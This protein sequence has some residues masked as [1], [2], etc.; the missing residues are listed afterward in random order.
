MLQAIKL[1]AILLL[2]S[3]T[4]SCFKGGGIFKLPELIV[5]TNSTYLLRSRVTQLDCKL[6]DPNGEW[7]STSLDRTY[8]MKDGTPIK[9][10]VEDHPELVENDGILKVLKATHFAEG[11]YQCSSIVRNV[12]LAHDTTINSRLVS[13]PLKLRRAR[14]TK[15][16]RYATEKIRVKAG[17]VARLPCLG[18]PDV[19]PG[20]PEIWFEKQGHEGVQLGRT[21]N[22]RFISTPTGLQIALTQPVDAGKYYCMVRNPY[23]NLTR[24]APK[25]MELLV[26][27][28]IR[29]RRPDQPK[30][31]VIVYPKLNKSA[32]PIE[33]H[34]V[35]GQ[36]AIL[37]CVISDA[38]IRWNKPDF[39][40]SDVSIDDDRARVRQIWGNL[41]IKHVTVDD[42]DDYVCHGL[43]AHDDN[44]LRRP[45]HPTITYRLIVHAPTNVRLMLA[46]QVHDKSWQLSCYAHNL[47]YEIP[48]VY[49]NGLALI[50]AMEEMGVPAQTNFYTNPINV[51]LKS[52]HPLS[53]S[54][55]CISRPAMEEAEIYGPGLER[56]RSMNL[57][58]DKRL[59]VRPNL[60]VQ[61]PANATRSMGTRVQLICIPLGVDDL[62]IRW[63]KDGNYLDIAGNRRLRIVGTAS[64]EIVGVAE[65]D[66]GLYT[67]EVS[68]ASGAHQSRQSARL[69]VA[70]QGTVPKPIPPPASSKEDTTD[71]I[72]FEVAKPVI[73]MDAD[74]NARVQW[75]VKASHEKHAYLREFVVEI[76]QKDPL[77]ENSST[78]WTEAD[79][80]PAHVR[81]TTLKKLNATK[82]FQFRVSAHFTGGFNQ[83]SSPPTDWMGFVEPKMVIPLSPRITR[84]QTVSHES[85]LVSWEHVTGTKYNIPD[86]FIVN[87]MDTS[88]GE[89]EEARVRN[90]TN[91]VLLDELLPGAEYRITIFAENSAGRSLSSRPRIAR[92]Y[93]LV[94][95]P[96]AWRI[97]GLHGGTFLLLLSLLV[98]L[99]PVVCAIVFALCR[100]WQ[101]NR[102]RPVVRKRPKNRA[103]SPRM[104]FF[105]RKS[106]VYQEPLFMSN[107]PLS[108]LSPV[109]YTI[110]PEEE[111]HYEDHDLYANKPFADIRGGTMRANR[112]HASEISLNSP[113]R[114]TIKAHRAKNNHLQGTTS[115]AGIFNNASIYQNNPRHVQ[116]WQDSPTKSSLSHLK[117]M[118]TA[119]STLS[120][121]T[122]ADGKQQVQR[123]AHP[124]MSTSQHNFHTFE[125]ARPEPTNHYSNSSNKSSPNGSAGSPSTQMTSSTLLGPDG[126]SPPPNKSPPVR[127]LRSAQSQMELSSF[128]TQPLK[129]F[130]GVSLDEP[131]GMMDLPPAPPNLR[132]YHNA[133]PA[134]SRSHL[135]GFLN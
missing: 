47:W 63:L 82:K 57:Y 18:L 59:N 132:H 1:S 123:H 95:E 73:F 58:V 133:N 49:V 119:R 17:E 114:S 103:Q 25:P 31:P 98:L 68:D 107:D 30:K 77:I 101:R 134:L 84:V 67:C 3:S 23:M 29:F 126:I 81:A 128:R 2:L 91:E 122:G 76:R 117:S 41:R 112:I 15:F 14:I 65:T 90:S 28:G 38:V 80:V 24:A 121:F 21:G 83:I 87:Y 79:R 40:M 97:L 46:Q 104:D 11:E 16:E 125:T 54:V 45:D 26:E 50:D 110:H 55:Q 4:V 115:L 9:E 71:F 66:A 60:I 64:L 100:K 108:E 74:H 113:S 92:T 10:L 135:D 61:G 78:L 42:S 51:T 34:V 5:S 116:I 88:S 22:Q 12:N 33:Y 43:K 118:P 93:V 89:V 56:G 52:N 44:E 102:E 13:A 27:P 120:V 8:W 75:S 86:K 69:S 20:P 96:S 32:E 124:S 111:D 7:A 6:Y 36:T 37:E 70:A 99:I 129:T 35:A 62:R 39:S 72:S 106:Q 109:N 131:E 127:Q 94:D 85:I 53:G 130:G 48:M 19:V 105:S